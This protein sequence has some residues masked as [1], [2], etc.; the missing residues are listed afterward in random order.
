MTLKL[1]TCI[2]CAE[3]F[4][5]KPGKPGFANRCPRCS[6]PEAAEASVNPAANDRGTHPSLRRKSRTLKD[7]KND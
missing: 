7:H 6:V 1:Q 2:L 3:S 5:L 4:E